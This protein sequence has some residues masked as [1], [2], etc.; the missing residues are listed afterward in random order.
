MFLAHNQYNLAA[1]VATGGTSPSA[2]YHHGVSVVKQSKC[3]GTSGIN[4]GAPWSFSNN[5]LKVWVCERLEGRARSSTA[6][7]PFGSP[8]ASCFS[9]FILCSSRRP[10]FSDASM[11]LGLEQE[12]GAPHIC[13]ILT[14][15]PA[16][17][18]RVCSPGYREI[19]GWF[20]P[21]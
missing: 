16:Q 9:H 18:M 17:D 11:C 19:E 21:M 5:T 1:Y 10:A 4:G 12:M 6:V 3:N 13:M 14:S 7:K 2:P 15:S 8:I 20:L